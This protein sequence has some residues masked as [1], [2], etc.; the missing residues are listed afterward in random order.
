MSGKFA[1]GIKKLIEGFD[2][3]FFE[4]KIDFICESGS[5]VELVDVFPV[6]LCEDCGGFGFEEG[7]IQP[8]YFFGEEGGKSERTG[9]EKFHYCLVR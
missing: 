3:C 6:A 2:V 4:Y 5:E 8:F 7:E 1:H 9:E